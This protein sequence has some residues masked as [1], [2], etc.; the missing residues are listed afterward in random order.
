MNKI[1]QKPILQQKSVKK[2]HQFG[3]VFTNTNLFIMLIGVI[4]LV[5]GYVLM[6]G[7]KSSDPNVFSDAIFNTQ[8]LVVAPI[9][10]VIGFI[11]EIYAIMYRS[12]NNNNSTVDEDK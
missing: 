6:I 3:F 5:L 11:I 4:F 10:L 1:K 7:G 8:R 2:E 12:K 9:L